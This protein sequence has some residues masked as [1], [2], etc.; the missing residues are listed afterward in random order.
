MKAKN[1]KKGD[2]VWVSKPAAWGEEKGDRQLG[3]L[4]CDTQ[5]RT[6]DFRLYEVLV[7]GEVRKVMRYQLEPMDDC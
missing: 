6:E 4:T 2:M 7:D 1:P 5:T 3:L